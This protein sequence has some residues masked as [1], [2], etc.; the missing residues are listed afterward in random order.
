MR[1]PYLI[2]PET[3]G[4][5]LSSMGASGAENL[6]RCGTVADWLEHLTCNAEFGFKP[7]LSQLLYTE[8]EQVLHT[9]LLGTIDVLSNGLNFG[10][11]AIS[12]TVV[13]LV[14]YPLDCHVPHL[15]YRD[16]PVVHVLQM[17]G[18]NL[19]LFLMKILYCRR[20]WWFWFRSST[21]EQGVFIRI[22]G[23]ENDIRWLND[24]LLWMNFTELFILWKIHL[25]L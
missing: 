6:K 3:V 8:L 7:R 4:I 9:Q 20:S 2:C 16:N 18:E 23:K 22:Q 5:I 25:C 21:E 13:S 1:G 17:L 19:P 14:C 24:C 15:T 12:N 11:M 10:R